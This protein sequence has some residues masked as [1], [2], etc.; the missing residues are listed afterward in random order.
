MAYSAIVNSFVSAI[1]YHLVY[2]WFIMNVVLSYDLCLAQFRF[3]L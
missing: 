2:S 3:G 1:V